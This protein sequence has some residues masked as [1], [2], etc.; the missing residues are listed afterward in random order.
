MN[1]S[2]ELPEG[3]QVCN[4]CGEP[5]MVLEG[6]LARAVDPQ[7]PECGC[8]DPS[9]LIAAA[10]MLDRAQGLWTEETIRPADGP[11]PAEVV[12][13]RGP[14]RLT[15]HDG[16]PYL[17]RECRELV[18]G[19]WEGFVSMRRA[20]A[21]AFKVYLN[22]CHCGAL[23]TVR[24]DDADA[25]DRGPECSFCWGAYMRH[26]SSD[27]SMGQNWNWSG[28]EDDP[29]FSMADAFASAIELKRDLQ[30]SLELAS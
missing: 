7:N 23:F 14:E 8:C 3:H 2:I 10:A 18:D 29:A 12:F 25:A 26:L 17:A 13:V 15:H 11:D 16:V 30:G 24:S 20:P 22:H 4:T 28:R 6:E 27:E 1:K 19:R 5:F 9:G 21:P